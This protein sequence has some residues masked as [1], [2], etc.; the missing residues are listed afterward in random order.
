[1]ADTRTTC[2]SYIAPA[3]HLTAAGTNPAA[4]TTTALADTPST[5]D[6]KCTYPTAADVARRPL[7]QHRF[8]DGASI[9][10]TDLC[11]RANRTV[12]VREPYVYYVS[13]I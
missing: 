1:M 4:I 7:I 2:T 3:L 8:R 13:L 9:L 10:N 11:M 12:S 6:S 5:P